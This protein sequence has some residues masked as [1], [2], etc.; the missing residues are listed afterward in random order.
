[1]NKRRIFSDEYIDK[2]I[3]KIDA[4][5]ERSNVICNYPNCLIDGL[6]SFQKKEIDEYI[7][8]RVDVSYV[9]G[10]W[11]GWSLRDGYKYE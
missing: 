8:H 6:L 5:H 2:E 10:F 9:D 4:I 11:A 3:A 1:M 7:K